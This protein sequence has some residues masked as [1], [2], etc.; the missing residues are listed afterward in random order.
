MF[1]NLKNTDLVAPTTWLLGFKSWLS[2]FLSI[3]FGQ[4]TFTLCTS[5]SVKWEK[6]FLSHYVV[7]RFNE[8]YLSEKS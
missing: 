2:H 7:M 8:T 3:I 4:V 1:S 5:F 6:Y